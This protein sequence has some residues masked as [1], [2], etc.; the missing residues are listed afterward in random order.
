MVEILWHHRETRWQPRKQTST[1]SIGSPQ[2][3][4]QKLIRP[5]GDT[6]SRA[7]LAVRDNESALSPSVA[8]NAQRPKADQIEPPIDRYRGDGMPI[9]QGT[10]NEAATHWRHLR[11]TNPI[12]STFA[13]VRLRHRRTKGS[14][15]RRACLAMVFKLV[16][17]AQSRW[18][19]LNG[20]GLIVKLRRLPIRRWN[21]SEEG[22]E[23]RRLKKVRTQN[24][25]ISRGRLHRV[26]S[27]RVDGQ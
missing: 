27:W 2:S 9:D 3:T 7:H 23:G 24:L 13:T 19:H 20:A 6:I 10:E 8:G 22:R 12:E 25:T 4:R 15:S 18:R 5:P 1:C 16:Q 26:V 21:R 17:I 11:T 14:G